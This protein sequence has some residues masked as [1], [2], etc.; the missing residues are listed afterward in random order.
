MISSSKTKNLDELFAINSN[1]LQS[2]N[3]KHYQQCQVDFNNNK[4]QIFILS[5]NNQR[6]FKP[7]GLLVKCGQDNDI[8][9]ID[10]DDKK[11]PHMIR[12]NDLCRSTGVPFVKTRKG[13]H[14]YFKYDD[15]LESRI[16]GNYK[17]DILGNN[18]NALFPPAEYIYENGTERR[19]IKYKF[20]NG[21]I[22]PMSDE[23]KAFISQSQ[24]LEDFIPI[25]IPIVKNDILIEEKPPTK[26]IKRI[27]TPDDT[28]TSSSNYE[29]TPTTSSY[30]ELP[31]K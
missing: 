22:I 19:L 20:V 24:P 4:K 6:Y 8:T 31:I 17:F 29:E 15:T 23:I 5:E 12:L 28:S 7:N 18:R 1:I 2:L 13:F 9:I 3:I 14:Y 10:I 21:T 30:S 27:T 26:S 25:E 11:H 16:G